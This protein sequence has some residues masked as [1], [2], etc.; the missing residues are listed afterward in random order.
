MSKAI[1]PKMPKMPTMCGK[2][3]VA[4]TLARKAAQV[5]AKVKAGDLQESRG[6]AATSRFSRISQVRQVSTV[7]DKVSDL[8]A[9]LCNAL[10]EGGCQ[11]KTS[12]LLY[13]SKNRLVA[14]FLWRACSC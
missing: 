3:A 9:S 11:F 12:G 5:K 7:E 13:F 10:Q 2:A 1:E 14:S 6:S 4:T 8:Q